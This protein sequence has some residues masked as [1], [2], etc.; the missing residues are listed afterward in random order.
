M[1]IEKVFKAL[2]DDMADSA[3]G[4]ICTEFENQSYSVQLDNNPI[5]ADDIFDGKH[6]DIEAKI[7]PVKVAL[8][9]NSELEQEFA[10]EFVEYHE[11]VFKEYNISK[12]TLQ[13]III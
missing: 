8:Y 4:I 7:E 1:N 13:W 12:Y 10:T 11:M 9:R 3:L 5:T 2:K 6:S